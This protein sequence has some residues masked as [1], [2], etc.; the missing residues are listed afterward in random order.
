MIEASAF[1]LGGWRLAFLDSQK[2]PSF[3]KQN[4]LANREKIHI[5]KI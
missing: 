1:P 5:L 2:L 3:V 4:L